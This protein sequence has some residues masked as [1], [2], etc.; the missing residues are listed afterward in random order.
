MKIN[1][2]LFTPVWFLFTIICASALQEIVIFNANIYKNDLITVHKINITDG[3]VNVEEDGDGEYYIILSS[4]EKEVFKT[5]FN[6][7]FRTYA[8][9]TSDDGKVGKEVE[10]DYINLYLRLP[11]FSEA[12]SIRLYRNDNLLYESNL[13]QNEICGNNI[14]EQNENADNCYSDCLKQNTS[15]K[16]V[17]IISGIITGIV[18]IWF[19]KHTEIRHEKR[20]AE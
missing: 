10:L 13:P 15:L 20:S 19:I 4:E 11:Y 2:I 17:F 6:L 7:E 14:C 3:V 9:G 8:D 16:Y 12:N 18:I 5:S 1:G